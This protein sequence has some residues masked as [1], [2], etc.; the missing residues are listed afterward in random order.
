MKL[1]I[2][3]KNIVLVLLRDAFPPLYSVAL[4]NTI[5]HLVHRIFSKFAL[6]IREIFIY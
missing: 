2:I 5:H 1:W 3:R 4:G 6:K